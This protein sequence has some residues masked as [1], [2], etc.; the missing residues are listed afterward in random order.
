[1]FSKILI[2]NRGEIAVRIM[3]TC[4]RMGIGT[5][6]VYSETDFR[7][8][9]VTCADEAVALGGA[10]PSDSYL[11]AEKIIETALSTDCQAIH[12]GYGFLSENA[13]FAERVEAAGLTFIGPPPAVISA[14]GDKIAAKKLARAAGVPTVPGHLAAVR[15]RQEAEVVAEKIGY[16]VLLKPAAGGG[17]KGMRIVREPGELASALALCQQ[18]TRK[19]FADE[20]IFIERYIQRPR[21]IEIQIL[22]D[23]NG[24][25]VHL[26][27]RECSIQRR[28]QKIIEESPS[29]VVHGD[30]RQRMGQMACALAREAG[31]VNAGTVEFILDSTGT[32]FFLEMNT[33]LQVEHPVTEM[34]TSTDLVELQLQIADGQ[35]LPFSQEDISFTG[36]AMEARICAED[37]ARGFIPSVG[38]ITRYAEPRGKTVRVDS[39]I[40][41]GSTIDV[42]YDPM[43]AKVITWGPD[44][45]TAR[46][47][48][49]QALNG[50]HIE[51]VSTNIDFTNQVL[52]HPAFI[53]GEL[54]TDFIAEH[55]LDESRRLDPPLETL[56]LMAITTTLIHYL[57]ENR[58]RNSLIPLKPRVGGVTASPKRSSFVAKSEAH[59]FSVELWK[60]TKDSDWH[61]RVGE[62]AYRV[63]TPPLEFYRRRLKLTI[64]GEKHYFRLRYNGNFIEVSFCGLVRTFEIYHPREW[65]LARYMPPPVAR[66]IENVLGCPMPGLIVEIK[67]KPGDRVFRGQEVAIIE[68][69]K[70]ESAVASPCDG[71]IQTIEAKPGDAVE[72]GRVL[73][74][75]AG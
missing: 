6:A 58:V 5:V 72:T 9:H 10:R 57:R 21:H 75:F 59:T 42:Y 34:V 13:A 14:L 40:H 20:S 3:A 1:M 71:V 38:L 39:G 64:N 46:K 37:P 24:N 32:F 12:P 28:Y 52:T 2:A 30:L 73:V 50:Y 55:L 11:K 16:P 45:E 4:R 60:E 51:G 48:M 49:V 47:R 23:R 69:M 17:G 29:C 66:E 8:L 68:S 26:G 65:N 18:E 33:R 15:S 43:L 35:P 67:V 53:R 61:I 63:A 31:Y 54:S 62:T 25:V 44:R 22:A 56:H 70:M 74:T 19:A 41:A 7:S 36:W 27:E